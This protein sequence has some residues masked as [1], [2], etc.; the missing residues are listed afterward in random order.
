MKQTFTLVVMVLLSLS[1]SFAQTVITYDDHAPQ[2][3]DVVQTTYVDVMEAV[4]PGTTG[5]GQ[6]WDFSMYT[7]G[8]T[9]TVTFIDPAGT[10]W[11]GEVTS[12]LAVQVDYRSFLVTYYNVTN[13]KAANVAIGTHDEEMGDVLMIFDDEMDLLHFPFAYGDSFEDTY[14]YTMEFSGMSMVTSG[15]MTYNADAYGTIITP[16]GTYNNVL[17]VTC[18]DVETTE[19]WF[20]GNLIDTSTETYTTYEWYS[21]NSTPPVAGLDIDAEYPDEASLT[22][23]ETQTGV[24]DYVENMN[25]AWPNPVDD[26]LTINTSAFSSESTI[27]IFNS[28]GSVVMEFCAS[29][30]R[31]E[32]AVD[33]F[34]SGIYFVTGLGVDGSLINKKVVVL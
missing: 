1:I 3:G 29:G 22:F 25:V 9:E 32:V 6:T 21:Q 4:D 30:N 16:S 7:G 20:N 31:I 23:N 15:T 24:N 11:G 12:N 34:T 2:I 14:S 10:L 18:V 13:S 17:R 19:T 27:R 26:V 5:G 33:D 28:T 8:E